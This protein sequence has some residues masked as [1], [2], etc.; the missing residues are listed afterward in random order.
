MN[1]HEN[2]SAKAIVEVCRL[3]GIPLKKFDDALNALAMCGYRLTPVN[4]KEGQG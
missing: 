1:I 3:T 4:R 2:G